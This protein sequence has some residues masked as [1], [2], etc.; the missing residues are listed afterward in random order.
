MF[1]AR[2]QLPGFAV[3]SGGY[4]ADQSRDFPGSLAHALAKPAGSSTNLQLLDAIADRYEL[5]RSPQQSVHLD[6]AY[7]HIIIIVS[8]G[9]C[10]GDS[11]LAA[12][13]L[14]QGLTAPFRALLSVERCD[15]V[16]PAQR[17]HMGSGGSFAQGIEHGQI[18]LRWSV[19][20]GK[21][22]Q[23]ACHHSSKQSVC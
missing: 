22:K 3:Q 8:A 6:A 4:P 21:G 18:S 20:G 19:S 16:V 9:R 10:G 12:G 11:R 17:V 15:V 13:Y 7:I 2:Q 14:W 23:V 1:H 5:G